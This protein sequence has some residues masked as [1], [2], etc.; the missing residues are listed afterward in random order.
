[1]PGHEHLTEQAEPPE[2]AQ[3]DPTL[4]HYLTAFNALSGDRQIGMG[5]GPIPWSAIDR[6]ARRHG[7]EKEAFE[8]L[9]RLVRAQDDEFLTIMHEQD[10]QR[11]EERKRTNR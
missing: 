2:E 3:L 8:L 5:R 4:E 11:E 6:Y 10:K 9:E 1:M 7:Y